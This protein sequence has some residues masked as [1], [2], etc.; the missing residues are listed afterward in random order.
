[1]FNNKLYS[2]EKSLIHTLNPILKLLLAIL[3]VI[4]IIVAKSNMAYLFLVT[5]LLIILVATN[6][7]TINFLKAIWKVRYLI[8]ILSLVDLIIFRSWMHLGLFI[9]S[10]IAIVLMIAT[11]IMTTKAIDMMMTLEIIFTPFKLFG[12]NPRK[13][14]LKIMKFLNIMIIMKENYDGFK[15]SVKNRDE[16]KKLSFKQL[17][18]LRESL[19]AKSIAKANINMDVMK[20]KNYDFK[21]QDNYILYVRKIDYA[22]ISVQILLFITI[23]MKG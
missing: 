18:T 3:F 17:L 11:L 19:I 21:A 5:F 4:T 1:M 22:I 6:I 2:D 14:A 13:M 15:K 9:V 7:S 12:L 8:I 10:I 16:D 23:L 20:I